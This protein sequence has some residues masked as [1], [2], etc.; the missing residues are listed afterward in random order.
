M[1]VT[2]SILIVHQECWFKNKVELG[3]IFQDKLRL[4]LENNMLCGPSSVV[5]NRRVKRGERK[6]AYKFN[7]NLNRATLSHYLPT[8]DFHEIVLTKTKKFIKNFSKKSR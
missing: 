6:R 5:G 1:A 3:C 2:V 7:K 4:N 8:R